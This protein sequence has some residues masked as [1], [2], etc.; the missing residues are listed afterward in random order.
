MNNI[1]FILFLKN[2]NLK[3]KNKFHVFS[4]DL[5]KIICT[6]IKKVFLLSLTSSDLITII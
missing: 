4:R 3:K 2:L 6:C 1:L 5:K